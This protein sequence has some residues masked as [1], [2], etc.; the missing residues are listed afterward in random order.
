[1]N[2]EHVLDANRARLAV[3]WTCTVLFLLRVVGQLEVLLAAPSW[4]PPMSDW[5]SGLIPYPIL[6]PVQIAILMLM[7]ALVMREMQTERRHGMP[8]VRRFAIVY[9]VAMV[10]RLLLQ[11]LRG[12]DNAIDAGGIP[13]AFHW[14]L[15]LF[16]LVLS[17]P[18]SVSMDVRA[19]RKPA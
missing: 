17:R 13:V 4:L 11:L 6:V 10:L 16:L 19:K 14:V 8:W 15:A 18:P 3:L 7:S 2:I 12:A 1:M 5:Y 9:F